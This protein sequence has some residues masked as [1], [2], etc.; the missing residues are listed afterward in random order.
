MEAASREVLVTRARIVGIA[1]LGV[2]LVGA[3]VGTGVS[4]LS[5]GQTLDDTNFR[6]ALPV[7]RPKIVVIG[8]DGAD[9]NVIRPLIDQGRMPA[10]AS[11]VRE[12]ASGDLESIPPMNSPALWTT[13]ATGVGRE[14]H[15]IRDFVYKTPGSYSQPTVNSTI[16]ERL[17]LWN[18]FS[19]LGYEVGVLNWYASWPAEEVNGFLVSDRLGTL[20]PES[21]GGTYPPWEHFQDVLSPG[22]LPLS[23][24]FPIVN[25]LAE[26]AA[27]EPTVDPA[28][29]YLF[30]PKSSV[31]GLNKAAAEDV[32]VYRAGKQLYDLYRPDFYAIYFKGID[33]V[34]HFFW[35]YHEPDP[36]V[37]GE[38]EEE[39]V[40]LFGPLVNEYYVFTD[41]LIGGLLEILDEETT[42][43]VVSDH[44]FRSFGRPDNM[45]FDLDRLFSMMGMLEFEDPSLEGDRSARRVR[46]AG[47][48]LYNHEGTNI[49]M[50]LGERDRA[51][52]LNVAG[53]DPEGVIEEASWKRV[54]GEIKRRLEALRTDLGTPVFSE[55]R[56]NEHEA[57]GPVQEP[58]LY[59]RCDR[60]I[61]FDYDVIIDGEKHSL[62]D[63]FLWEYREIS[64]GHREQGI[65][66]ARG[67][68]I[69]PGARVRAATVLD[70]APTVLDLAG[71]PVPRDFEGR[72]LREILR[73][74]DRRE[75]LYVTSYEDL[76]PRHTPPL[77]TPPLDPEERERL[78][79][80]GY[81]Q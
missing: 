11:L 34:S 36:E 43:L 49:V 3:V 19:G 39:G 74:R 41:Q 25:R 32:Y 10:L 8:I 28:L 15:G 7:P 18:I 63:L 73:G 57:D 35:R 65:F 53:R 79:A 46:M 71:A 5:C 56:I 59:L 67:P 2:I 80:L 76:V 31:P 40:R 66:L 33:A 62:V 38:V 54:R 27:A 78:R 13:M 72:V 23:E 22:K 1:V 81:T 68:S 21:E 26:L 58:D 4:L 44:G 48:Q 42:V 61:A 69:E 60:D 6:D 24:P 50:P 64:G 16:R 30:E 75:P 12:G 17:A 55:V 14:R 51:V 70:I 45:I 29:A 9:W 47:S 20:G 37:Y 52:Y 77:E